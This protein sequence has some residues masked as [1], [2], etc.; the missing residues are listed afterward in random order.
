MRKR[1]HPW[2]GI[3]GGL[4]LGIALAI[5]SVTYSFAAFGPLTPWILLLLGI[6]AGL[7]LIFVPRPWGQRRRPRSPGR[8]PE[9]TG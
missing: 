4:L 7:A 6:V 8:A 3:F 1:H 5:G 2:R 9:T